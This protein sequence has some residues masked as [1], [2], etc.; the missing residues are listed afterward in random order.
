MGKNSTHGGISMMQIFFLVLLLVMFVMLWVIT[1]QAQIIM[2][3]NHKINILELE[4]KGNDAVNAV[5]FS[6][7]KNKP[8]LWLKQK[9]KR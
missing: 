8:S 9:V 7:K 6:R 2:E 5:V 1:K 4:M 3:L